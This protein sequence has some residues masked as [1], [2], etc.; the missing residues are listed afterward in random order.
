MMSNT[1][2]K[3]I[4]LTLFGESHGEMI[5]A[6]LD[7][8]KPGILIDDDFIKRML[9]KRRP[10][11]NTETKRIE[12]DQYKIISGVFNNYTTGA[13]L[14]IVI[15]NENVRSSD[16]EVNKNL[17]R[18][19]H[20]DYVAHLKYNGFEDYRGGGHFSGRLTAAIVVAGSIMLKA[21]NDE[22]IKI[23]THILECAGIRDV[24]FNKSIEK[25]DILN[26]KSYPVVNDIEDEITK[27]IEEVARSGDSIGGVIQT[28]ITGLPAGL[29]EP[30]FN[31][32]E[33]AIANAVLS[34]GGIKGIEFGSGF[35]FKDLT[36]HTANDVFQNQ[37]G[38][39]ITLTNHNGG[40][41]GGITNGMPVIF[42]CAVKPTP[43][44]ARPQLTINLETLKNSQ[45]E[46]KGRHDPAIIRRICPVV[47]TLTA[48]V[49]A[50]MV[51]LSKT[52][53]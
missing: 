14:C 23:E 26:Q 34:I 25:I 30:W 1:I 29:G 7:G 43:S 38:R 53:K 12:K 4:K 42:N 31:S 18:P 22:G 21:L 33:G 46:I 16:Y 36:G 19:S 44:I 15:P 40:I 8:V 49:I 28:V 27:R 17:A 52:Y 50:D 9:N 41:N 47:T 45:I 39:V 6:V 35:S 24:D 51:A 20:A 32:M 13:P 3:V 37:Q 2:G 48:V 10:S 5:G 11:G